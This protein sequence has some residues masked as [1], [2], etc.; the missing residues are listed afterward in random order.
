MFE[1][2][3]NQINKEITRARQQWGVAFDDK[4]TLNDY[5]AYINIYLG[6]ATAM[7]IPTDEVKRNLYKAAG[8]VV[9]ALERLETNGRFAPRH[10]DGQERPKSLPEVS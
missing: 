10:Y 8:L 3:L 4:N 1:T 2:V 6:K 5:A 9:T 7:G